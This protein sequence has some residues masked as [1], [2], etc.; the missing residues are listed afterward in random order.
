M[1]TIFADTSGN[2]GYYL[3]MSVPVRQNKTPFIGSRVLD[4]TTTKF[5]WTGETMDLNEMP[6]G[7][8]PKKGFF[9]TANNPQTTDNA[10]T[11]IGAAANSPGRI[12]RIDEMLREGIASGKKFTL[13]DMGAIQ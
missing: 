1:N 5:D 11:D 9:A 7:L 3:I 12:L 6:R 10:T 8:N 2:I 4:G 13:E